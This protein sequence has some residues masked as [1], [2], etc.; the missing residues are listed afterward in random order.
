MMAVRDDD[1]GFRTQRP[2][3]NALL[4]L[5]RDNFALLVPIIGALI[6]A[7]RCFVVTDG[8]RY[9]AS[10]LVSTTSVG[11]AI[12][13]L[14]ITMTPVLL[15]LLS[16][17]AAFAAARR[18]LDG[19]WRSSVGMAVM[20]VAFTALFLYFEEELNAPSLFF[21]FCLL[22]YTIPTALVVKERQ[23]VGRWKQGRLAVFIISVVVYSFLAVWLLGGPFV[24]KTFWLP[25]ER[26]DFQNEDAF[27]GYVLKVSE[28]QLMILKD[29]PRVIIQRK[30]D[31]LEDRDFC[32]PRPRPTDI[33]PVSEKVQS[34]TPVC[35]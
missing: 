25:R 3:G 34:N 2:Q 14:F 15:F 17:V 1:D 20:A 30:K 16:Y 11:D 23:R 12:R 35:P 24:N 33:H 9:V 22:I 8:D 28:G 5:A 27:T 10:T 19:S 31:T 6:F 29:K 21:L 26:L 7:F 18:A 32:H 4:T 13:A